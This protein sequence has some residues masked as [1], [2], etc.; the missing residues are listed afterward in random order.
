MVGNTRAD[1]KPKF[2]A[3]QIGTL[4]MN[5]WA[6]VILFSFWACLGLLWLISGKKMWNFIFFHF[7]TMGPVYIF[8][9]AVLSLGLAEPTPI[10]LYN[11]GYQYDNIATLCFLSI[12]Y[13]LVILGFTIP[14]AHQPIRFILPDLTPLNNELV[15][16]YGAIFAGFTSIVFSAYVLHVTGSIFSAIAQI[17]SDEGLFSFKLIN[18]IPYYCSYVI[19]AY[20]CFCIALPKGEDR[21]KK[22]ILLGLAMLLTSSFGVALT[23]DRSGVLFPIVLVLLFRLSLLPEKRA[24]KWLII[25]G[26]AICII[27]VGTRYIRTMALYG[28]KMESSHD[29]SGPINA[30]THSLNANNYDTLQLVV[31]DTNEKYNLRYGEDFVNGAI[32]IVPRAVW[33]GKPDALFPDRFIRGQYLTNAKTG[34]PVHAS[35]QWYL[36]YGIIGFLIGGLLTGI[37]FRGINEQY[38]SQLMPINFVYIFVLAMQVFATG[39]I[40]Q[41]VFVYVLWVAPIFL[42][43]WLL[44]LFNTLKLRIR[45]KVL[46]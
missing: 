41:Q 22:K 12:W 21:K 34:W 37:L 4:K 26:V 20:I 29:F 1:G 28:D 33:S 14:K 19:A 42:L 9:P 35:G 5:I 45:F 23:G 27:A 15:L 46:A 36:N 30:L 32:A 43:I 38:Q 11:A 10:F 31:R 3:R 24:I 25:S 16:K 40:A 6:T 39:L 2:S 7:L 44:K 18:K 8:R 17:R 13:F